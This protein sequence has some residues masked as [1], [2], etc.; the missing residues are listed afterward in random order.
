MLRGKFKKQKTKDTF[1][2]F[3]KENLKLKSS[4]LSPHFSGAFNQKKTVSGLQLRFF[5]TFPVFVVCRH[6]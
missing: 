5:M 2:W 1:Y 3:D 6:P 4:F